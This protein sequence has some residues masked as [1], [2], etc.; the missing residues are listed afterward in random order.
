M[1]NMPQKSKISKLIFL[2]VLMLVLSSLAC[3]AEENLSTASP[4]SAIS[5]EP[6]SFTLKGE[7]D[8]VWDIGLVPETEY[9][10]VI[11]THDIE[12]PINQ[13]GI[14]VMNEEYV[15]LQNDATISI[16]NST[17]KTTFT[18][19]SNGNVQ[20]SVYSKIGVYQELLGEHSISI[21]SRLG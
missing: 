17:V 8:S 21:C 11:T 7:T 3:V 19:P 4:I 9:E 20:I 15:L 5:C 1:V 10:V 13:V 16:E 12:H 18:S 14:G 6:T 2:P